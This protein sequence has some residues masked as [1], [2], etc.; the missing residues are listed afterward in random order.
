MDGRKKLAFWAAAAAAALIVCAP[1][2]FFLDALGRY[3]RAFSGIDPAVLRPVKVRFVPHRGVRRGPE[4]RTALDFVEFS[5]R[6]PKAKRVALIGDF[7]GWK[8]SALPMM[9]G[10]GGLWQIALPLPSGRHLYLFVVDGQPELDS[11]NP[12]VAETGGRRASVRVVR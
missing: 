10:E 11:A 1:S 9:R 2:A 3:R 4:P 7:N 5:L 8:D 6:K 12:E